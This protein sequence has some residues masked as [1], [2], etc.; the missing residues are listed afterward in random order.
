MHTAHILY[1]WHK[2]PRGKKIFKERYRVLE[3]MLLFCENLEEFLISFY[4]DRK[5][6]YNKRGLN[7]I[8]F[9]LNIEVNSRKSFLENLEIYFR[10][11]TTI[12]IRRHTFHLNPSHI[13][14]NNNHN[15]IPKLHIP[16]SRMI[17]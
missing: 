2:I 11:S 10:I 4:Y 9:L 6:N 17:S 15:H 14:I 12:I 13:S 3:C 16:N 7:L 8:L 5:L 1:C